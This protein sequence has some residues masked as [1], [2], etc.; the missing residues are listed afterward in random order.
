[1]NFLQTVKTTTTAANKASSS[2][3]RDII[4]KHQIE[5]I[6]YKAKDGGSSIYVPEHWGETAASLVSKQY[7]KKEGFT[8]IKRPKGF[9]ITW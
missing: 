5:R 4:I 8:I 9:N 6:Q 7:F 2:R 1:M 3:Y